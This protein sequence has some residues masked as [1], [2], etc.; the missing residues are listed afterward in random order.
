MLLTLLYACAST[1]SP[2]IETTTAPGP[3]PAGEAAA[4]TPAPAPAGPVGPVTLTGTTGPIVVTPVFHG[5][6]RIEGG[7][8][9]FWVDPWSK[10][11]LTGPAAD[12][13]LITDIHFDHLDAAAITKVVKADTV[14][15]APEAVARELKD[16]K[17]DHVL[18]NGASVE[19]AGATITAVPMYNLVRGPES[20]KLFHDKGRGNGYLLTVD[21]QTIYIA[22]DT[23]C[24]DEM[25][26]L[27]GVDLALLP[28]NL[29]YTMPPEEAAGCVSAFKPKKVTPYHY[30]GSDL[31][32][33][34]PTGTEVVLRDAY[35]GGQPW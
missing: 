10:A 15:V 25:K 2:T 13:V 19:L 28:M 22:G 32:T 14:I 29:P 30:A 26:A 4:Q 16:R 24:T 1:P 21:G 34:A 5:T 20:G 6:V 17:V 31:A 12:V 27:V 9:V 3:I 23:E 18:A 35:P 11:N 8:K 33:F 7:G